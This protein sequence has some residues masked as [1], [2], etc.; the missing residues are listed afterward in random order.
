MKYV[1]HKKLSYSNFTGTC[2][3]FTFEKSELDSTTSCTLRL[4]RAGVYT[5]SNP[6]LGEEIIRKVLGGY[7]SAP[8]H[9]MELANANNS[10]EY[11]FSQEEIDEEKRMLL[12]SA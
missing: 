5:C 2:V 4:Y 11:K 12:F 7:V 9:L 3:E 6:Y 1:S 10:C 8:L